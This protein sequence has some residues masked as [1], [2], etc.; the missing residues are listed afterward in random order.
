[1]KNRGDERNCAVKTASQ[2]DTHSPKSDTETTRDETR[3]TIPHGPRTKD[4]QQHAPA[5]GPTAIHR[6]TNDPCQTI[7]TLLNPTGPCLETARTAE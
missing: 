4:S 7:Q 2:A 1:M 5:V 3:R 6:Q